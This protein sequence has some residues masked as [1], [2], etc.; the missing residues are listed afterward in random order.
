MVFEAFLGDPRSRPAQLRLI[1][2]VISMLL[3]GPPVT[4]FVVGA[5]TRPFIIEHQSDL[6]DPSHHELVYFGVPVH[7]TGAMPGEGVAG[8]D[9]ATN[10]LPGTAG[11][12]GPGRPAVAQAFKRKRRRPLLVPRATK[13]RPAPAPELPEL[14]AEDPFDDGEDSAGGLSGAAT[15]GGTG[16]TT[17]GAGGGGTTAGG[18]GHALTAAGGQGAGSLGAN[19]GGG[20]QAP[21]PKQP[22]TPSTRPHPGALAKGASDENGFSNRAGDEEPDPLP[23]RPARISMDAAAY[24]RTYEPFPTLPESCW[25]PGRTTNA[26]MFEICVTQTGDVGD[27][28]TRRSTAPDYDAF[29]ATAIRTWRYR[30]RVVDGSAQ[31]FCHLM[32]ITYSRTN[33]FGLRPW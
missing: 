16:G 29:L 27:V 14:G 28:I 5:L 24:L 19:L 3:H 15:R 6:P 22:K 7:V 33:Q 30:P 20:G 32:V 12:A 13:H 11:A 9:V 23:G 26:V 18:E 2:Y 4:V 8:G 1:G 31:P 21:D 10:D 17:S 25:P